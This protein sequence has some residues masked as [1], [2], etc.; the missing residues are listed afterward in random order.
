MITGTS[1]QKENYHHRLA[2][3]LFYIRSVFKCNEKSMDMVAA[4]RTTDVQKYKAKRLPAITVMF[5]WHTFIKECLEN[6]I[7]LWMC[8]GWVGGGEGE[9]WSEEE[10]EEEDEED[11]NAIFEF[12]PSNKNNGILLSEAEEQYKY[13][14]STST[15][16]TEIMQDARRFQMTLEQL[17][18]HN[19]KQ[20][21]QLLND[22]H[23]PTMPT[24]TLRNTLYSLHVIRIC[25]ILRYCIWQ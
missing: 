7:A 16:P 22:H 14:N 15:M 13:K 25:Y 12:V 8:R 10:E 4:H 6:E 9:E 1:R 17:D 11:L 3:S 20:F 18:H 24:L 21:D 23:S 5:R 19:N 2:G